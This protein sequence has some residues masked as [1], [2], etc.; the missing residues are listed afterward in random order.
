MTRMG[1]INARKLVVLV[2]PATNDYEI[3]WERSVS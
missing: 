3:D 2:D 1:I